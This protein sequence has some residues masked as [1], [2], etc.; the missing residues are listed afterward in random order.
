MKK[1]EILVF[2]AL[3][4]AFVHLSLHLLLHS[5][6]DQMERERNLR[7]MEI[8]FKKSS[9]DQAITMLRSTPKYFT[10][11]KDIKLLPPEGMLINL[12]LYIGPNENWP[13]IEEQNIFDMYKDNLYYTIVDDTLTVYDFGPDKINDHGKNDDIFNTMRIWKIYDRPH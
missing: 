4:Y 10:A 2:S 7:N 9:I 5:C 3:G 8:V 11:P 12:L 1:K 6:N 13:K